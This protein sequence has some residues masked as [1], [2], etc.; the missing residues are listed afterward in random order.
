M[1]LPYAVDR[2][3]ASENADRPLER[4]RLGLPLDILAGMEADVLAHPET[5]PELHRL[6]T[7]PSLENQA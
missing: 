4:L 7:D 5:Y 3:I 1:T 6:L 2:A